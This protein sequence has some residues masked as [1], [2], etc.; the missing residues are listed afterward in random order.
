MLVKYK[1]TYLIYSRYNFYL[2]IYK[3]PY[4]LQ[5][6]AITQTDVVRIVATEWY[7]NHFIVNKTYEMFNMRTCLKLIWNI[8]IVNCIT[9]RCIWNNCVPWHAIDCKLTDDNTTVSKH[10]RVW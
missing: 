2:S 4:L 9:N 7:L 5:I 10:V 1:Q 8:L 3:G 6:T